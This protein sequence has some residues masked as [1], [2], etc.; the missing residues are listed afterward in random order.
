MLYTRIILLSMLFLA[1]NGKEPKKKDQNTQQTA[2]AKERVYEQTFVNLG[3]EEQYV[4]IVGTSVDNPILLFIHGGPAWPQTPQLR[5]FNHPLT[6]AYTLVS[7]EQRGAGQSYEKNPTPKNLTLAQI[8]ADGHEL[9]RW[10]QAKYDKKKIF[11]AGYSW[12]SLVGVQMAVEHPENYKAYIGIAQIVNMNEG[13][14]LSRDWLRPKAVANNDVEKIKSIDSLYNPAFYK[15]PLDHFFHQ[16]KLL[17]HYGGAVYNLGQEIEA[18]NA[19]KFYDDY[20]RYEWYTVWNESAQILQKDMFAANLHPLD[21][22]SIP[23]FLMEGRH[24]WNIP[25]VLAEKWLFNLRAPH[26][27]LI[28]FEQSGHGPLEEEAILFNRSM[29]AIPHKIKALSK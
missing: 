2:P 8:V 10:L 7:W 18:Q 11:L 21:T 4:E 19:M 14:A 15:D 6:K 25:S 24:D 3:G 17:G 23:V 26:K 13:M 22:L 5:Y 27:E 28:W 29:N 16:W 12:G 1:C 9:T 20:R